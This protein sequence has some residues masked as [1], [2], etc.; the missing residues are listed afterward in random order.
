MPRNSCRGCGS[1][2]IPDG[3]L[4]CYQC[5]SS[6]VSMED[7]EAGE[8]IL[9]ALLSGAC[10]SCKKTEGC[11]CTYIKPTKVDNPLATVKGFQNA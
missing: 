8:S 11:T 9:D 3:W 4:L 5:T 7:I 6:G 10:Q 1:D 2:H